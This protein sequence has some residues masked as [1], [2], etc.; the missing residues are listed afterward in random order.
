MTDAI[1]ERLTRLHPKSIDLSLGRL[2]RLLDRLG[3]PERRLP[4]VVHVSGT[5]GKGSVIACL[6]AILGAAGYR[7]HVYTSPHLIR[8]AERI[9]LADRTIDE[10]ELAAVLSVCE[11]ANGEAPITFFEITT[12]AAFVAFAE[13]QADVLLLET[14][15]GGRLDATNVIERPLLTAITP[16]AMDH[17][18]YLGDDLA[19]IAAEKAG[20]LKAEVAVVIGRQP[21][22]AARA[23]ADRAKR[24]GAPM[25]PWGRAW[26][27]QSRS[28]GMTYSA[29]RRRLE[30]PSPALAGEHQIVNA[31]MAIACLEAMAG[32]EVAPEAIPQGLL[33]V[34]W[35]GRLQRLGPGRLSHRLPPGAELWLDGGHNP[36]AGEALAATL[37][38][39]ARNDRA[40]G[41]PPPLYLVVGMLSS[42]R[43]TD[44][45]APLA[46]LAAGAFGIAIPDEGASLSAPEVTAGARAAGLAARPADSLEQAL[47]AIAKACAG[48]AP[49]R[50]L[51]CGSLYLAGKVLA[52][53]GFEVV[54]PRAGTSRAPAA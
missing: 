45:L 12:A 48:A 32:F 41:V 2:H 42:K 28:G 26:R 34:E 14:G 52:S 23:I 4:P 16:V 3:N 37:R 21:P 27:A 29:G 20:I 24:V 19:T 13:R 47:E 31:G 50:V 38:A 30:L 40:R 46:P 25:R 9:R 35:P 36:G 15:L 6:A 1:L 5:N 8:F 51:I 22:A 49:P 43:P 10:D 39:W 7:A 17:M 53:E 33:R 18:H 44:F 54:T 11:H